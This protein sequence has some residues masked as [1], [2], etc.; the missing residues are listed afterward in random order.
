MGATSSRCTSRRTRT[1]I[2]PARGGSSPHHQVS[3]DG[4]WAVLVRP[5]VLLS[6]RLT[7][8]PQAHEGVPHH[9]ERWREVEDQVLPAFV[10]ESE[11]LRDQSACRG[12]AAGPPRN[13]GGSHKTSRP[14]AAPM[15]AG[16]PRTSACVS[17]TV[18]GSLRSAELNT[19]S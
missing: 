17:S 9:E 6:H 19:S 15:A 11:S 13:R 14:A 18:G 3:A 5:P 8:V 12:T 1:C 16:R 4:G 2:L 7:R 10:H